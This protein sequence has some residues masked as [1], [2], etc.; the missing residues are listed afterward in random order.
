MVES[1]MLVS[2][3]TGMLADGSEL[4]MSR[5]TL[6]IKS[7]DDLAVFQSSI[8]NKVYS[9]KK[10][11]SKKKPDIEWIENN[12]PWKTEE[13]DFNSFHLIVAVAR[14]IESVT[15]KDG[16]Y[17]V[18]YSSNFFG[19][20]RYS[21]FKIKKS[22]DELIEEKNNEE[23]SDFCEQRPI[24]FCEQRPINM[25]Q[26]IPKKFVEQRPMNMVQK[27]PKKFTELK[28]TKSNQDSGNEDI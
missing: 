11:M 14:L 17:Y 13:V 21:L 19:D 1:N 23:E 18:T 8:P 2:S 3:A 27:K 4:M 25:V 20:N 22:A 9:Y 26:K 28:K 10:P 6:L 12:D 5:K 7:N 24:N 16:F 15:L